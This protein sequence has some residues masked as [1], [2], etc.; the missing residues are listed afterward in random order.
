M[1]KCCEDRNEGM[2]RGASVGGGYGWRKGG[3]GPWRG[4]GFPHFPV[5]LNGFGK[6]GGFSSG[7]TAGETAAIDGDFDLHLQEGASA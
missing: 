6:V 3:V 7:R 4:E 2:E 1:G 5:N